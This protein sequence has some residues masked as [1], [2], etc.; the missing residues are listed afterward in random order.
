MPVE[1]VVS[2][3]SDD[4]GLE[5]AQSDPNRNDGTS[6]TVDGLRDHLV[7]VAQSACAVDEVA[8]ALDDSVQDRDGVVD[9]VQLGLGGLWRVGCV[10]VDGFGT[11]WVAGTAGVAR[12]ARIA[13]NPGN[14]GI[15]IRRCIVWGC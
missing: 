2:S 15:V 13:G 3:K 9:A 11:R 4:V 1:E 14:A 8:D 6:I 5:T 7:D 12:V 10:V